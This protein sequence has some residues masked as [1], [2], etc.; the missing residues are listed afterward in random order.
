MK[1]L[2]LCCIV[3]ILALT[4]CSDGTVIPEKGDFSYQV[5]EGYS[6]ADVTDKSCAIVRDSDGQQVG[7]VELT[8]LRRK[9]LWQKN[10]KNIMAYLHKDFHKAP[11]GDFFMFNGSKKDPVVSMNL[12]IQD[13]ETQE[14]HSYSHRFFDQDSAVYHLWLDRNALGQ[15]EEVSIQHQ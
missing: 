14:V 15:W 11:I 7:G 8:T 5:T 10:S 6:I 9:D 2:L 12:N 13:Q 3:L 1:R 4:G